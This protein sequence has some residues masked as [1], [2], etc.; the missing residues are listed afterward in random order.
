MTHCACYLATDD[1][2]ALRHADDT[3]ALEGFAKIRDNC[4]AL[5]QVLVPD[6][7]WPEFL[8]WH[9]KGDDEATHASVSFLAYVRGRISKVTDPIH[10]FLMNGGAIAQNAR[11]QYLRDLR[12][13]WLLD[14]SYAERHR[15]SKIFRGRLVE[16]QYAAWLESQGHAI[17]GLEALRVGPDIEARSPDGAQTA[18][19]IKFFGMEATDFQMFVES[20]KDEPAGGSISPYQAI[21]YLIFRVY[22]A[23]LQLASSSDQRVVVIVVDETAWFR[24]SL[25]F[26]GKW[27]DWTDPAF[28]QLDDDFKKFLQT[29]AGGVPSSDDLRNAISQIDRVKVYKQNSAFEFLLKSDVRVR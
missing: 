7:I 2:D 9:K 16:L 20:L 4:P 8:E 6:S 25:Q 13:K 19:E 11:K 22:Q 5:S 12:E 27:I 28:I 24:F 14:P 26:D 10:Q 17:T 3:I 29:Q 21:N 23:A 1:I 15:L 18:Y